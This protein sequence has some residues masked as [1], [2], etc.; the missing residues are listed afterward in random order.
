MQPDFS[1]GPYRILEPLGA[2]GIGEVYLAEDTRLGRRVA[3]KL[4]RPEF[5]AAREDA[6]GLLHEART[7][8]SL[9][10]PNICTVHE[11]G[12]V[13]G[14]SFIA[15]EYVEGRNLSDVILDG[16][17]ATDEVVRYGRQLADALSHAHHRGVVHRDL[18]PANV[19]IG[20]EGRAKVLDFGLALQMPR[21]E[22]ER[23]AESRITVHAVGSTVG[24]LQY[25]APEVFRGGTANRHSDIWSLGVV[26]YEMAAGHL[27][28]AGET[29]FALA[30]TI[31][32]DPPLPL[33]SK[34]P[35]GLR[36]VI[37]RCL[38]KEPSR[39]YDRASEVRAALEMLE[40]MLGEPAPAAAMLSAP[41]APGVFGE[42]SPRP[43]REPSPSTS[44]EPSPRASAEPSSRA[45]KARSSQIRSLAVLPLT[46]LTGDP[47][48]A[49][50]SDGMTEALINDLAKLGGIKVISRTSVMRYRDTSKP[51][52][53]IAER[54]FLRGLQLNPNLA[55]GHEFYGYLLA[56]SG[57]LKEAVEAAQRATELDPLSP[58]AHAD[59]SSFLLWAGR[60]DEALESAR[61]SVRVDP[62]RWRAHWALGMALAAQ[63]ALDEGIAAFREGMRVSGGGSLVQMSMAQALIAHGEREQ[64]VALKE[65]LEARRQAGYVSAYVLAVLAA[66]LGN[67]EEALA[68]LERGLEERTFYMVFLK[69]VAPIRFAPIQDDPRF[70]R[71]LGQVGIP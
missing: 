20:S 24:T 47:S 52:P 69:I 4:L 39:R 57:R 1:L 36:I 30:S 10:H 56:A 8:A 19:R 33:P 32:R 35:S 51:L 26:L 70:L 13:D 6:G 37:G 43:S 41:P 9:N 38:A 3:V 61:R 25:M 67:E 54:S 23:S 40:A 46:D 29:A 68:W 2:G 12:E 22:L 21:E 5:F 14:R 65:E 48:Q 31:L 45:P 44:S 66:C 15:M 7:A 18:K 17:M 11:V 64:A 53:E 55:D 16:G 59:L 27:P 49:Y 58:L 42:S 28:F 50:F 71:I 34:V 60:L 62:G 63:G